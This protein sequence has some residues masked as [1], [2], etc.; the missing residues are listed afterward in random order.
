MR[1]RINGFTLIEVLIVL[2]IIGVLTAI[3]IPSYRQYVVRASRHQ[4]EATMLNLSQMEERY[5]TNNYSYYAVNTPP[6]TPEPNGWSNFSGDN[7]NALKYT[8][9]ITVT[10]T[11]DTYKIIA[12][13]GNGFVD[14]D[15]GTLTLDNMGIKGSAPGSPSTCW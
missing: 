10:T 2:A 14:A 6:P 12:T 8:I 4:A 5:F 9:T 1:T 15:C 11:P 13:P 3:A 7:I